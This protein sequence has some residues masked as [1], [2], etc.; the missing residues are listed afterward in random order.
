MVANV[1]KPSPCCCRQPCQKLSSETDQIPAYNWLWF[2]AL[3]S[4]YAF[5]N[6]I[7]LMVQKVLISNRN[8]LMAVYSCAYFVS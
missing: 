6:F 4:I 2:F 7:T 3:T 5:Q 8:I 1:T